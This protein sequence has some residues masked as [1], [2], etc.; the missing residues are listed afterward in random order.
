MKVE[1]VATLE[2][3]NLISKY[4]WSLNLNPQE[5][6]SPSRVI[7]NEV[8]TLG[9]LGIPVSAPSLEV[10]D[11]FLR[12]LGFK[13][14]QG[15]TLCTIVHDSLGQV[16]TR[17]IQQETSAT[18]LPH[19]QQMLGVTPQKMCLN[20]NSCASPRTTPNACWNEGGRDTFP[21]LDSLQTN[22]QL[23]SD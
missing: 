20:E 3:L 1:T 17:L 12:L 5:R 6:H 19:I 7:L 9:A 14:D 23:G 15:A 11:G 10:G 2:I 8:A 4:K 21:Q 22:H 18:D 13:S 16:R